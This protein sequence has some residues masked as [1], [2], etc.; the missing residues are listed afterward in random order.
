MSGFWA[1]LS[2]F[3]DESNVK[4]KVFGKAWVSMWVREIV[5]V[6]GMMIGCCWSFL[7]FIS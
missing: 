4:G 3:G 7:Y 6:F 1:V 2:S 5:S